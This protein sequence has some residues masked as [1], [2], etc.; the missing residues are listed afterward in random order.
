MTVSDTLPT[1][2]ID[3]TLIRGLEASKWLA[4]MLMVLSH[5]GSAIGGDIFWPSFWIGRFCAP[6]FA[7]LIVARL[8]EKPNERGARYLIRLLA[9]GIPAQVPFYLWTQ[10]FGFILNELVVWAFGV[11]TIALWVK[12]FRL[13]AVLVSATVIAAAINHLELSTA[14]IMLIAYLIYQRSPLWALVVISA[15]FAAIPLYLHPHQLVAPTICMA[16]PLAVAT[17]GLM[18][19][20]PIRLPGWFFY[21]IYPVHIGLIFLIFGPLSP[22]K[23]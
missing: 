2:R 8:A 20:R 19:V 12:G 6:I 10:P 22:M 23:S 4:I 14:P 15:S 1:S 13:V 11:V 9:W 17:C 5:L 18:P 16:T 21:A 7:F 3:A